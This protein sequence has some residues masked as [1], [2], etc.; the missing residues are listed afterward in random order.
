MDFLNN[1][2]TELQTAKEYVENELN[3]ASY[4]RRE[5][6][7][8]Q[9][10]GLNYALNLLNKSRAVDNPFINPEYEEKL[11]EVNAALLGRPILGEWVNMDRENPG[12]NNPK[13]RYWARR[14]NRHY[15]ASAGRED[16]KH[17]CRKHA[18]CRKTAR[19]D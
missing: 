19:G 5:Q 11:D 18:P 17:V 13:A 1:L 16:K 9:I 10:I 12:L 3:T 14:F 2:I 7:Q 6:L 15:F 8:G 4:R